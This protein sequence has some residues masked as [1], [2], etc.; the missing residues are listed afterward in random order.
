MKPLTPTHFL[1]SRPSFPPSHNRPTPVR[2][3]LLDLV[4]SWLTAHMQFSHACAPPASL[5]TLSHTC[6]RIRGV[7][8]SCGSHWSVS[9]LSQVCYNQTNGGRT[10]RQ[11]SLSHLLPVSLGPDPTQ[12]YMAPARLRQHH[13]SQARWLREGNFCA[14]IVV[15]GRVGERCRCRRPLHTPMVRPRPP[16][17]ITPCGTWRMDVDSMGGSD[18]GRMRNCSLEHLHRASRAAVISA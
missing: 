8:L 16:T 1:I 11:V 15:Q 18:G 14:A 13:Q 3:L 9:S 4:S 2:A 6:A 17:R 5:S 7:P 12:V 10:S